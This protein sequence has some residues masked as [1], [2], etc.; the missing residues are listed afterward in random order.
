MAGTEA[1]TTQMALLA[2][3]QAD[4]LAALKTDRHAAIATDGFTAFMTLDQT[5]RTHRMGFSL[6][7]PYF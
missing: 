3:F 2:A 7:D 6:T 4:P 1:F 5:I